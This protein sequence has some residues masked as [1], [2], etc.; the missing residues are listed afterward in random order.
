[1]TVNEA[2]VVLRIS[3]KWIWR[4]SKNRHI[5]FTV[6]SSGKVDYA[7]ADLASANTTASII[8]IAGEPRSAGPI[9]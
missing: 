2:S 8:A 9:G 6:T 1:M 3:P 5:T 7:S 4:L